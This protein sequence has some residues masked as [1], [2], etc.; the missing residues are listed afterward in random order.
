[1]SLNRLRRFI[2]ATLFLV[3]P[4]QG[5]AVASMSCHSVQTAAAVSAQSP[6]A[7]PDVHHHAHVGVQ[8]AEAASVQPSAESEGQVPV[9]TAVQSADHHAPIQVGAAEPASCA[10]C[11]ACCMLSTAL[12]NYSDSHSHSAVFKTP[13]LQAASP[14]MFAGVVPEGL[15]RPPR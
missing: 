2:A 9:A 14:V 8:A 13:Q 12:P 4:L 1:M 7:A 15:L 10:L 5:Q 3:L 11:V 6:A